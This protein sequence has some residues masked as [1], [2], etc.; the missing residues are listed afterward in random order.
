MEKF[1]KIHD[2]ESEKNYAKV[3][4]LKKNWKAKSEIIVIPSAYRLNCGDSRKKNIRKTC[5]SWFGIG[6]HFFLCFLKM[7][8]ESGGM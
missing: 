7:H 8:K 6:K 1:I 2:F 3:G 5:R 4:K